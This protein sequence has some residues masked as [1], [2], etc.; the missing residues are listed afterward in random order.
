MSE[1]GI[2][3]GREGGRKEEGSAGQRAN[4]RGERKEREGRQEEGAGEK[5]EARI[6]SAVQP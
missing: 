3:R 5:T 1:G 2:K 6:S 4:E